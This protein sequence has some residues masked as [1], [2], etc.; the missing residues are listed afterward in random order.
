[1]YSAASLGSRILAF[2]RNVQTLLDLHAISGYAISVLSNFMQ[3]KKTEIII[4]LDMTLSFPLR[5]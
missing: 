5:E 3:A 2:R 1:M 4:F